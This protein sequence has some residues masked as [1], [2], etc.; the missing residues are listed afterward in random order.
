[1][2]LCI[3]I[4]AYNEAPVIEA[5]L[6]ALSGA[7]EH[8][9]PDAWEIIVADNA[10]TDGT[11]DVAR[12]VAHPH[13]RVEH[14]TKKG[15]GN[16]LRQAFAKC[17]AE[18]VGFTDADLSVPPE[19][20]AAFATSYIAR[21]DGV[22][23]G[24]RLHKDSL[25][26]G[27][28]WWRVGSSRIFNI[29]ARLILGVRVSDTQCPLKLMDAKGLRVMLATKED[30]WFFDLEWIALLER[31]NI[32]VTEVPVTWDEHRYPDRKSKLST[33]KDGARA[34]VAMFRIRSRIPAQLAVL[35][36]VG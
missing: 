24:S 31:L 7:L 36:N 13:I 30:T 34:V 27:R 12:R 11:G 33:V 8:E 4:P 10:S 1:M 14:V 6:R 9:L 15:K 22:L 19:E 3:V 5:T 23:I 2:K 35:Q 26:P 18:F 25:M 16:A 17:D 21:P 29:L 28:E 32:P 20:V